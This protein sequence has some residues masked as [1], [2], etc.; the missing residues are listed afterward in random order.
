[1]SSSVTQFPSSYEKSPTTHL[2]LYVYIIIGLN[3]RLLSPCM[4]LYV[5]NGQFIFA[6]LPKKCRLE[7]FIGVFEFHAYFPLKKN[8]VEL[9][10][11]IIT[12]RI[13]SLSSRIWYQIEGKWSVTIRPKYH[14]FLRAFSKWPLLSTQKQVWKKAKM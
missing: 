14:S 12:P 13:L 11:T 4:W 5:I 10:Y 6:W 1:M 8:G 7:Y 2:E 3:P 9:I